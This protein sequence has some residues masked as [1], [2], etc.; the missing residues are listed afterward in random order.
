MDANQ[1]ALI[2]KIMELDFACID[3]NLYLDTHPDDQ[4]ALRDYNYYSQQS[5]SLKTQYE[6]LYGPLMS[7]GE[8]PSQCNR[9]RW[10]DDPWPWEI[11]Y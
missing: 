5:R 8:T 11:Q 4:K 1:V 6:Q 3:L 10:V 7:F 2:K 9:F